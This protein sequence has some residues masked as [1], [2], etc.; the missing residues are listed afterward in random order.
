VLADW[1]FAAMF[2]TQNTLLFIMRL[3]AAGT[4]R[5]KCV[6]RLSEIGGVA[7]ESC[8][9]CVVEGDEQTEPRTC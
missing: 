8:R 6:F 4:A 9:I 2:H 5:L 3:A 7:Q 1:L